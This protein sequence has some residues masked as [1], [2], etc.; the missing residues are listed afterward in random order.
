MIPVELGEIGRQRQRLDPRV[1]K[2][3]PKETAPGTAEE[4]L[5]G[6]QKTGPREV[7]SAGARLSPLRREGRKRAASFLMVPKLRRSFSTQASSN[8]PQSQGAPGAGSEAKHKGDVPGRHKGPRAGGGASETAAERLC[9]S[10]R[11]T[12]ADPCAAGGIR[13]S[14]SVGLA[15]FSTRTPII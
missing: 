5:S 14:S 3:G 2:A 13:G 7:C 12:S 4:G 10:S 9:R 1:K 15:W 6:G 8:G 11:V